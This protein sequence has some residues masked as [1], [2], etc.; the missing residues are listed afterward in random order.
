M[1]FTFTNTVP[2]KQGRT[3]INHPNAEELVNACIDNPGK[4]AKVPIT[5][6]YP[7]VEGAE[8]TK[9]R[10]RA[11]N[12][13]NRINNRSQSPFGAYDTEAKS[14]GTDIYI[15]INMTQRRRRQLNDF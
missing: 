15:R 12:L 13:A 11:G 4:W 6:L 10:N 14:R 9:L 1:E 3:S 5:Y 2:P 8:R 7:D